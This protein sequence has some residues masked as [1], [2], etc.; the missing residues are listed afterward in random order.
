MSYASVDASPDEW[1][2]CVPIRATSL[3]CLSAV[4]AI[5]VGL[6]VNMRCDGGSVIVIVCW[7]TVAEGGISKHRSCR[8]DNDGCVDICTFW[9]KAALASISLLVNWF[10]FLSAGSVFRCLLWPGRLQIESNGDTSGGGW[11]GAGTG[12]GAGQRSKSAKLNL[13]CYC[14]RQ[15]VYYC[16]FMWRKSTGGPV[17]SALRAMRRTGVRLLRRSRDTFVFYVCAGP[18]IWGLLGSGW[19]SGYT[20]SR[21]SGMS[22]KRPCSRRTWC[23]DILTSRSSPHMFFLA[24]K[25]IVINSN[26]GRWLFFGWGLGGLA[27]H[28]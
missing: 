16:T 21:A 14:N 19:C 12:T 8:R 4:L 23:L 15:R 10:W 1:S 3:V 18:S 24:F 20:W 5:S 26:A 7:R 27:R 2:R 22:S 25:G 28:L 13:Y 9:I 17:R 11:T 6:T